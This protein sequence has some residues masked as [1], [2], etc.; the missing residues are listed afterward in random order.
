M[1]N[2]LG[3]FSMGVT[4]RISHNRIFKVQINATKFHCF[5]TEVI[6]DVAWLWYLGY[7]HLI[8][9]KILTISKSR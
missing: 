7:G 4:A 9:F 2:F 5:A 1:L 8:N 3:T 6:D